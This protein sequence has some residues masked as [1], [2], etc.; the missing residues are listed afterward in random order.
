MKILHALYRNAGRRSAEAILYHQSDEEWQEE[1]QEEQGIP[2]QLAGAALLNL[3]VLDVVLDV[4][5][6]QDAG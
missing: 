6:A 5:H 2:W 1:Q 4:E 3:L